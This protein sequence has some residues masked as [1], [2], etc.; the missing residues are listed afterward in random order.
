MVGITQYAR[1]EKTRE[2]TGEKERMKA[3]QV[4]RPGADFEF[5]GR[6]I[7]QPGAGHVRIRVIACGVCHSDVITKD[8]VFPE[9]LPVGV[10]EEVSDGGDYLKRIRLKPAASVDNLTWVLLAVKAGA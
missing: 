2:S 6:E 10:A 3:V 8:G 1:S 7:P 5:V 4:P 9:G